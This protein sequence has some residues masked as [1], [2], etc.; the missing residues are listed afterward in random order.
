[1]RCF[2]FHSNLRLTVVKFISYLHIYIHFIYIFTYIYTF[3][4]IYTYI[5]IYRFFFYNFYS[6][7]HYLQSVFL[8][9]ND[10]LKIEQKFLHFHIDRSSN[11]ILER[12]HGRNFL[13]YLCQFYIGNNNARRI[14][15]IKIYQ[16]K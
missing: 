16:L 4:H 14:L 8:L 15:F 2:P 7:N 12:E 11:T 9:K 5:H 3:T 6:R 1:M 10:Y 13:Q